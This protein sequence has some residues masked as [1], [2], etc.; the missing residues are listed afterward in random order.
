MSLFLCHLAKWLVYS[1]HRET[2]GVDDP[3]SLSVSDNSLS[4]MREDKELFDGADE[5]RDGKLNQREFLAF[6]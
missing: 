2:Y 3:A 6:R 5:D 4:L 1:C